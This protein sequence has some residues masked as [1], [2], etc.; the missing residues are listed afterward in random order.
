[1]EGDRATG[2][3]VGETIQATN[4]DITSG[5]GFPSKIG[6]NTPIL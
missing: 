4:Q 2:I 3:R 6:Y 1:M 5:A